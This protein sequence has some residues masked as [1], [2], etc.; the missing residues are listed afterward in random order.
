MCCSLV[1]ASLQVLEVGAATLNHW[2]CVGNAAALDLQVGQALQVVVGQSL[3]GLQAQNVVRRAPGGS[4]R[5]QHRQQG[6]KGSVGCS[7]EGPGAMQGMHEA[8]SVCASCFNIHDRVAT[9]GS[10]NASGRDTGV[11]PSRFHSLSACGHLPR[12]SGRWQ[13]RQQLQPGRTRPSVPCTPRPWP[14]KNQHK[15][16]LSRL[17]LKGTGARIAKALL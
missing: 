13:R 17:V 8:E 2:A 4:S 14:C 16:L 11:Q 12:Q 15:D 9:D 10:S 5:G 3:G 6:R 7:T 1:C